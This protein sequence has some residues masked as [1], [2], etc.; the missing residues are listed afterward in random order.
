MALRLRKWTECPPEITVAE[1]EAGMK[2]C[3][4][5]LPVDIRLAYLMVVRCRR[6]RVWASR[7]SVCLDVELGGTLFDIT[8]IAPSYGTLPRVRCLEPVRCGRQFLSQLRR[9]CLRERAL[10]LVRRSGSRRGGI[11]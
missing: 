8:C 7:G 3:V 5:A 2:I 9:S 6:G 1:V 10:T 11:V 4:R